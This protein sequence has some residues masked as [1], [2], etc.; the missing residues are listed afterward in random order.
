MYDVH[1][2][3][4][5]D[6]CC[7]NGMAKGDTI[8]RNPQKLHEFLLEQDRMIEERIQFSKSSYAEGGNFGERH[9]FPLLTPEQQHELAT[10]NNPL[11]NSTQ[12]MDKSH[13]P[14]AASVDPSYKHCIRQRVW[15]LKHELDDK[16]IGEGLRLARQQNSEYV[17]AQRIKFLRADRYDV[18]LASAR[19]IRFFD[20]KREL[21]CAPGYNEKDDTDRMGCLGRDLRLSDFSKNDLELWKNTGFFQLCGM[22]YHAKR[23]IAL[24]FGKV[25]AEAKIPA[26]LVLRVYLYV[27]DLLSRD[28]STQRAGVVLIAYSMF[29]IASSSR[30][31]FDDR[32][33]G[34]NINEE[35]VEQYLKR[36]YRILS[37]LVKVGMAAQLQSVSTHFCIDHPKLVAQFENL[38]GYVSTYGAAWFRCHYES[39]QKPESSILRASG[40]ITGNSPNEVSATSDHNHN[41]SNSNH[42]A[43][44]DTP[45]A[46]PCK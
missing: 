21:F 6:E 43:E 41:T 46:Q 31:V 30:K 15:F 20:I 7:D 10:N 45:Q 27:F 28:E 16:K 23:A 34:T 11:D 9:L 38:V 1:G 5:D 18:N 19:M 37:Q 33:L 17:H 13:V 29:T 36:S 14:A 40:K 42:D 12:N 2:I 3:P 22:R 24:V 35:A 39:A 8:D 32:E 44:A 25:L 26:A 4:Q